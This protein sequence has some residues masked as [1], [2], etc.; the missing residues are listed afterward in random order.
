MH[1][2]NVELA[3]PVKEL[4]I[5]NEALREEIRQIKAALGMQASCE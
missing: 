2:V 4:E 1:P 5:E 3:N